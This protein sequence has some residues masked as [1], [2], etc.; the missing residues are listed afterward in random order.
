MEPVRL[1]LDQMGKNGKNPYVRAMDSRMRAPDG[2][3]VYGRVISEQGNYI[4]VRYPVA[5]ITVYLIFTKLSATSLEVTPVME[6]I[7]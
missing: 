4:A 3:V 7:S 1:H 2:G 5:G 6:M